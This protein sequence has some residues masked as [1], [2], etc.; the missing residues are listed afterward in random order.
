MKIGNYKREFNLKRDILMPH[1]NF[2]AEITKKIWH[3]DIEYQINILVLE[4][5]LYC[6]FYLKS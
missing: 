6:Q 3:K 2:L 4:D 5:I 1:F